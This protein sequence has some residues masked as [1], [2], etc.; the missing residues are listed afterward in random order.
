MWTG[1]SARVAPVAAMRPLTEFR[2]LQHEGAREAVSY[3]ECH[4]R[5]ERQQED[6]NAVKEGENVNLFAVELREGPV[7]PSAGQ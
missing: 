1:V 3:T 4:R 6:A 2:M 7:R 5:E